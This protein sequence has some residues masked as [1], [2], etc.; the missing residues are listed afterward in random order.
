[1]QRVSAGR[2]G[3]RRGILDD[4]ELRHRNSEPDRERLDDV[5]ELGLLVRRELAGLAL[6]EDDPVTGEVRGE[7]GAERQRERER[8]DRETPARSEERRVGKEGRARL[9]AEKQK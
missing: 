4:V 2:E 1:M 5:V 8:Q 6:R 7:G 3:V 9:A